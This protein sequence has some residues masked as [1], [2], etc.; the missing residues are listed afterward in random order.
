MKPTRFFSNLFNSLF[1][2]LFLILF[3]GVISALMISNAVWVSYYEQRRLQEADS[4]AVELANSM[5]STVSFFGT[6]PRDYRHVILS[7]L[8]NMGGARFFVSVNEQLIDI[9][10]IEADAIASRIIRVYTDTM[11]LNLG[12]KAKNIQVEFARP[13]YLKVFNN[14]VM[15]NELPERWVQNSLI[16][17]NRPPLLVAQVEFSNDEWLYLAALL[18]D[19]YFLQRTVLLKLDQVIFIS[20]LVSIL[21]LIS[22]LLVRWLTNPLYQLAQAARQLGKDPLHKV[23]VPVSGTTEILETAHAFN[24]MQERLMRFIED[25]ERLFSAI[26]HDLKTPITRLRLRAEML[27]QSDVRARIIHD[28]LE[29]DE[30]VKGALEFSR[31]TDVHESLETIDVMELLNDI[32]EEITL[33]GGQMDVHGHTD[34][35]FEGKSLAIKRCLS[36]L[37]HNA[38]FYG[39][40]ATVTVEDSETQLCIMI[41]DSGSGIPE[42]QLEAVFE[43]YVRLETSRSRNTGGSGLGLSIARNIAHAHGGRLELQNNPG[44]G[45]TVTVHLPHR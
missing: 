32:R 33:T 14:D 24:A 28:L 36:N 23:Q 43:P 22:W 10:A 44:G 40:T 41:T 26:S 45:L 38:V 4:A 12:Q 19:P 25:R 31:S 39:N 3:L 27:E 17:P 7:Q 29:L 8:R 21:M 18:P 16:L 37:I 1:S 13:E 11:R 5:A 15:F 6:L 34:R 9:E 42:N 2:R 35:L 30:L 20:L